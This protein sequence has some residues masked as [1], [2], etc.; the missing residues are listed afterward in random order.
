MADKQGRNAKQPRKNVELKA[1]FYS[2]RRD[3]QPVGKSFI[4]H[5]TYHVGKEIIT[6]THTTSANKIAY[7][8]TYTLFT[9]R[10]RSTSHF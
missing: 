3:A 9:G 1:K 10:G 4:S 7:A 5:T 2:N 6:L 8:T